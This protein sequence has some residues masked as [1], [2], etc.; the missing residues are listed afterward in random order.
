MLQSGLYWFY[1]V[2]LDPT[3]I[4]LLSSLSNA[5]MSNG[6]ALSSAIVVTDLVHPG[7][8]CRRLELER[9]DDRVALDFLGVNDDIA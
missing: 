7:V 6:K 1:I 2:S 8:M 3:G 5:N 4:I 9:D